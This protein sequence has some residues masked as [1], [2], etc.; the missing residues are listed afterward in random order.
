MMDKLLDILKLPTSLLLQGR[1]YAINA[2]FRPCVNIMRMFE[3]TDLSDAEK[4][5]CMVEIFYKDEIPDRLR[6]EAAQKAVWF[7]NLGEAPAGRVK[8]NQGGRLF[9]WEQDLKFIISAADKAAGFSIRSK[10][11]YHFWEFM[12]AFFESGECVFNTLVH[13]RK[14]KR[15]GKQTKADKEWWAENK[16]IAELKIELSSDEQEILDTFN[17]L[18]EGGEA[19]D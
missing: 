10:E 5:D 3:R 8:G 17:K 19:S 18:L 13:Q 1:E 11:F 15:T 6:T 14:L 4:I 7:L 2:D 12:S 9:S 16:D